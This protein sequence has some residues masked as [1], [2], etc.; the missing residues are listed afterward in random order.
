MARPL[1]IQEPFVKAL[2]EVL[3]D[4]INSLLLDEDL[5]FLTNEKLPEN[6]RICEDTFSNYVNKKQKNETLKEFFSLIKKARLSQKR[7]LLKLIKGKKGEDV[8]NWTR[9]SWILERKFPK[10]YNLKPVSYTHLT[11][12]TTPYV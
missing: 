4:N 10:E 3:K 6:E 7:E 12:P 9:Y 8:K 1:K 5:V 2:T 11:L